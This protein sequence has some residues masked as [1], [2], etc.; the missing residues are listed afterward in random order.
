MISWVSHPWLPLTESSHGQE[1][2]NATLF[3]LYNER[4]LDLPLYH[5]RHILYLYNEAIGLLTLQSP[6]T[7]KMLK[8]SNSNLYIKRPNDL[9]VN[10]GV[11]E[12]QMSYLF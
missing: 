8:L 2:L 4:Q 7:S 3:N 6:S 11:S 9:H 10:G 12:G 1:P 5:Q